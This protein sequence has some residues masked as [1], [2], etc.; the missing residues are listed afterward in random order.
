MMSLLK[1]FTIFVVICGLILIAWFMWQINRPAS[2]NSE[3]VNFTISNGEGVKT[4]SSNLRAAGLVGN[5]FV[6]ETWIYLNQND[7]KFI[8]GDYHLPANITVLN[9]TKMLTGGAQPV[10][11]VNITM[12]EGWTI[13]EM[14]EAV[15]KQNLYKSKDWVDFT[16]KP[17]KFSPLLGQLGI[18]LASK[19]SGA[20]LE[21]YLFPDT[22]RVYQNSTVEEL[23]GKMLTNFVDKIDES[24]IKD[25]QTRGYNLWQAVI[26]ASI[27]ER[28]VRSDADRAIVSDIFWRRLEAGRGLEADST[29][30]YVTG[31]KTP[32]VTI[33]D[34]KLDSP[35]NTYKY[36]GL[37]PGPISNPGLSSIKAAIYPQ[38]NNYWYFLTTPDGAVIFSKTFDDHIAAKN[39][40][41]R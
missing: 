38:A 28:E 33:D 17:D 9:L 14:A 2:S 6:F 1:K 7:E 8:A 25:L 15:E 23:V 41:L 18:N 3:I 35:Y 10:S 36:R 21:G 20:S 26:M 22:Y 37:P 34:T 32:S 29:I 31:K 13:K 39:K 11:E 12:I 4:I 40:Y 16:T 5:K 19:P 24:W 27:I 30:N